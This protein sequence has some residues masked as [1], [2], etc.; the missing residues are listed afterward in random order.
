MNNSITR[1]SPVA[2]ALHWLVALLV[3]AAFTLGVTMVEMPGVTPTKL[4][5]FNYHKWIGV[6]VLALAVIR[7]LW[8]LSHPAPTLPASIPEWQRKIADLTHYALYFLIFA[9]PLSGFFYSL[10]SGFPVVYLG[11]L[12]LPVLIDASPELKP[13]FK[14]AHYVFNIALGTLVSLHILAALKHQFIDRDDVLKRMLPLRS[15]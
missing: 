7:L 8:R 15:R 9:V 12:P 1:Y 2:I 3:I 11:V 10:A 13:L 14:T 4:R 5:Y 6:T